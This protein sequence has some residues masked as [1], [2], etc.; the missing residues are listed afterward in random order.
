LKLIFSNPVHC[1]QPLLEKDDCP[2]LSL[3]LLGQPLI[4]RN[5]TI[6]KKVHEIDT[7]MVPVGFSHV[8][9]LVQD[10][11][12]SI[13]VE[14][15]YDDTPDDING[16]NILY[17]NGGSAPLTVSKNCLEMPMNSVFHCSQDGGILSADKITYPWEL[18]NAMKKTLYE[19][20]SHGT[21]I[22][23]NATV[24]SSTVIDGPCI[25]EDN[26][27]VDDFCKIKGPVYIG[28]GS[29]IGMGSL[30]RNCNM[31]D[32]TKIGF[33][34]EIARSYFQGN[35][36]IAHHNV[37]LDS[38]IGNNVWF[39]GYT[40]TANVLLN[41]KNIRY[42]I[43][44]RELVDTGTNSFG[45][46]IGNNSAVGASVIILPGRQVPTNAVVQAGTIVGKKDS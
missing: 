24:S 35:D 11:F 13:K 10:N 2:A 25:I 18:L 32:N 20:V 43:G 38:V 9:N 26:V 36:E 21:K 19:E 17:N 42:E 46:V 41:K 31:G 6:A 45:T 27:T 22:S 40:G 34:C 3:R 7:V 39:G 37:I 8:I 29:L 15:Y 1:L 16:R 44:G 12:P 30:V 28:S 33:N 14:E 5:I 23:P 4:I